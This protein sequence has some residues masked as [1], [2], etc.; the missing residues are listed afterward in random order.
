MIRLK[1][2]NRLKSA[3]FRDGKSLL[4]LE[5]LSECSRRNQEVAEQLRT[6]RDAVYYQTQQ[7]LKLQHQQKIGVVAKANELVIKANKVKQ[8][9][10]VFVKEPMPTNEFYGTIKGPNYDNIWVTHDNFGQ[11]L[12]E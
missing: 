3:A 2:N 6:S 11:E 4:K 9:A 8:E 7:N 1:A 10:S 5:T 12:D